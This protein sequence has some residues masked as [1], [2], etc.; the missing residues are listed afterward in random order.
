MTSQQ[1]W[2]PGVFSSSQVKPLNAHMVFWGS[3]LRTRRKK[4]SSARWFC[5]SI[6]SPP[7]SVSPLMKPGR[8]I[9]MSLSSTAGVKGCP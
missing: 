7:S 5:G 3:S 9:S 6:G 4:G 2:L 1:G 8:S